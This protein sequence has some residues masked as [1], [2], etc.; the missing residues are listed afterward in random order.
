MLELTD[1]MNNQ[2]YLN[3]INS[4]GLQFPTTIKYSNELATAAAVVATDA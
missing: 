1:S 4:G 3:M 2:D